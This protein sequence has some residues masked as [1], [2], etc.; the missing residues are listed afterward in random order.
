MY[1]VLVLVVPGYRTSTTHLLVPVPGNLSYIFNRETFLIAHSA[2]LLMKATREFCPSIDFGGSHVGSD[3]CED[4]FRTMC[5]FGKVKSMTRNDNVA[6][7]LNSEGRNA[8]LKVAQICRR[9]DKTS[10]IEEGDNGR[11]R[12]H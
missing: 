1:V 8:T 5:G 10:C 3:C 7:C 6:G 2:V 11:Q 12:N 4:D 9:H